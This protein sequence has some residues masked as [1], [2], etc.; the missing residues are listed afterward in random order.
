MR[1][2]YKNYVI[3][4]PEKDK[5][6]TIKLPSTLKDRDFYRRSTNMIVD[7]MIKED[8]KKRWLIAE[9]SLAL[10]L[11]NFKEYR[12]HLKKFLTT[13][14]LVKLDKTIDLIKEKRAAVKEIKKEIRNDKH[15]RKNNN[16]TDE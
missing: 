3:Y 6:L 12:D 5:T 11:L 14:E 4:N 7:F 13:Q 8:C 16:T 9:K 10:Y 15:N 2:V 1:Y